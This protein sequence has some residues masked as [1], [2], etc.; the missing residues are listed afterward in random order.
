M[1]DSVK[2]FNR[3]M[4]VAIIGSFAIPISALLFFGWVVYKLMQYF[5]VV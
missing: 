1:S 4:W 3:M 5:G 2:K